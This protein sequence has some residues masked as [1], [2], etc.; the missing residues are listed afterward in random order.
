MQSIFLQQLL[1]IKNNF[2]VP[3][4]YLQVY[5]V[6]PVVVCLVCERFYTAANLLS[7][8]RTEEIL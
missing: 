8:N 2:R 7:E 3:D 6:V 4:K 5:V 1:N